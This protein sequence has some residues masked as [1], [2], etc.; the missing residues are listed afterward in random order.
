M[1]SIQFGELRSCP[2]QCAFRQG[3][4]KLTI[5]SC[6]SV[7]ISNYDARRKF[8]EHERILKLASLASRTRGKFGEHEENV[9]APRATLAS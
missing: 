1:R 3:I 6:F 2:F 7:C 4:S 9:S 8:G 5:G